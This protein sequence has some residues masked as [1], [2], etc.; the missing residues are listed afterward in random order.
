ML[1]FLLL[2]FISY[3]HTRALTDMR[4]LTLA[5]LKR[6]ESEA[7][8]ELAAAKTCLHVFL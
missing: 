4:T 2:F 6:L 5:E 8:V 3:A 7:V 1:L